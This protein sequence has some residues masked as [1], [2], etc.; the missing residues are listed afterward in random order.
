MMTALVL[1][2]VS[3]V[4]GK[5]ITSL[6]CT[7]KHRHMS[8]YNQH[9]FLHALKYAYIVLTHTKRHT[10][11]VPY[12]TFRFFLSNSLF[13]LSHIIFLKPVIFLGLHHLRT[14]VLFLSSQFFYSHPLNSYTNKVTLNN[15][16]CGFITSSVFFTLLQRVGKVQASIMI[17]FFITIHTSMLHVL[18]D[19]VLSK[20]VQVESLLCYLVM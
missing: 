1:R 15:R 6:K 16:V 13:F 9:V 8:A 11:S 10:V 5:N 7:V 18:S 3:F 17:I 4:C 2:N 19:I 20:D 14:F 12:I